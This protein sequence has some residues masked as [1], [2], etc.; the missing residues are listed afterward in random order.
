MPGRMEVELRVAGERV[1]GQE[2]RG[3]Q[4]RG[5]S[6]SRRETGSWCTTSTT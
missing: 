1:V 3:A 2:P 4:G 5:H 6:R